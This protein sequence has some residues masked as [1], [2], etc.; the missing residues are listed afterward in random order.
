MGSKIR[1][2]F[3]AAAKAGGKRKD[4]FNLAKKEGLTDKKEL[5]KKTINNPKTKAFAA[6][7]KLNMEGKDKTKVFKTLSKLKKFAS[8]VGAATAI[9]SA[10][11]ANADEVNMTREDFK[12]LKREKKAH[13]GLI[14]GKPK[15]ARRGWR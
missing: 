11:P 9:F 13:G 15:L 4:F 8:P 14:R 1:E 3:I 10:D 12:D 2:K 6:A 7:S 5:A